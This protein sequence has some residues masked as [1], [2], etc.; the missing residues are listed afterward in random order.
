MRRDS[1]ASAAAESGAGWRAAVSVAEPG[2]CW[3]GAASVAEPGHCSHGAVS[4]AEPDH[5]SHGA[6]PAPNLFLAGATRRPIAGSV[7]WQKSAASGAIW[8]NF[9]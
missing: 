7:R 9:V 1:I 4:V 3:H 2:H 5:C 6:G 8:C